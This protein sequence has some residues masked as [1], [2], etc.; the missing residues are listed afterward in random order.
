MRSSVRQLVSGV[1]RRYGYTVLVADDGFDALRASEGH[2]K[3]IHLL[4]TD[5]VM[6]GLSGRRLADRLAAQ[7]PGI[8][9][10]YM[11]GY[12]EHAIQHHGVLDQGRD[13]IEKPFTPDQLA[14]KVRRALDAE[15]PRVV[16][17]TG[18]SASR[19]RS[20]IRPCQADSNR[21]AISLMSTDFF[22]IDSALSEEERA[23]RDSVRRFVDEQVLPI[24]GQC[25]VE[26]R[27]PKELIPAMAEL[28]LFGANLPEEVRLRRAQQRRLRAHHAGARAW[29]LRRSD[30]SRR[31]RARWRC[32]P[33]TPSGATS[34]SVASCPAMAA[35]EIIG[36]FGLTEPD[37]GSNPAGMITTAREKP[38]RQLRAER[39]QDVD[40]QRIDGAQS[41]SSG[42]R[43][44]ATSNRF[45]ASSC[46]PIRKG[47]SAKDQKGKLSL[48]ASDTSELVIAGRARGRDRS[49]CPQSGGLKSPLMCLTQARY[50]IA[51]GAL[52]AAMACYEEALAYSKT[53]IMFGRPIGGFQLQQAR[54]ADMLTEIVKGQL[55]VLHLGRLKDAGTSTPA[56]GLAR[57]AQQ[58]GHGDRHRPRGAPAAGRERHPRRVRV[59][60]AHGQPRERLHLRGHA[61]HPHARPRAGH[62]GAER[63]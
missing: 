22:N 60:A 52:G 6:P 48:R 43:P 59:D 10:L 27:F 35:G 1:L 15:G 9:V 21:S 14:R 39:L 17:K 19:A 54:L 25:Y 45:G 42:P 62:H 24:I 28:G 34:R 4:L 44:G 8:R 47:F 2:D 63:V 37:F 29:R 50:G 26:G 53:R 5:V 20:S 3:P 55:L 7:R 11:S 16:A 18:L 51:W 41:P 38:G 32:T 23:V 40:H 58:R 49:Y 30:R 46:R 56:A 57:Q 61:R 12:T 31:C 33:S 36:C 13:F